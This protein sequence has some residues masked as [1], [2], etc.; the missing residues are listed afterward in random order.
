MHFRNGVLERFLT[1]IIFGDS[2]SANTVE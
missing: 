1:K 2:S